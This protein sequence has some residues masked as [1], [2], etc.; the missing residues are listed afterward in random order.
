MSI[1]YLFQIVNLSAAA[2]NSLNKPQSSKSL[3]EEYILKHPFIRN[4]VCMMFDE[5]FILDEISKIL[6]VNLII[7]EIAS[8]MALIVLVLLS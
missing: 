4:K 7:I 5:A 8:P 3:A 2:I 6:F 1:K